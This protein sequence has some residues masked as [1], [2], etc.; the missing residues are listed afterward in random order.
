MT[1]IQSCPVLLGRMLSTVKLLALCAAMMFMGGEALAEM[2]AGESL[3]GNPLSFS[4]LYTNEDGKKDDN[5]DNYGGYSFFEKAAGGT[6]HVDRPDGFKKNVALQT[7]CKDGYFTER[8]VYCIRSIIDKAIVKFLDSF[9]VALNA[10]TLSLVVL[11][12]TLFGA[13][14]LVGSVEKPGV[15]AFT[16]LLKIGAV[17]L[18]TN[19]FGG[20]VPHIFDS[21]ESLAGYAMSYI[22]DSA[23]SP[24]LASCSEAG[25]FYDVSIWRRIDCIIQRLFT[26][27]D[28]ASGAGYQAGVLWV[29]AVAI[30]WTTFLGFF[31]FGV[32]VSTFVMI[33]LLVVRCVYVFLSAYAMLSLLIIISP[34]IIPLVL[35]KSTAEHFTK[36]LKQ[37]M[38]MILLPMLLFAYMAFVFA[39]IDAMFFK[40][41]PY[42]LARILGVNWE[43]PVVKHGMDPDAVDKA[44]EEYA[45]KYN[46]EEDD[47]QYVG[48]RLH[49]EQKQQYMAVGNVL[50]T[51]E[52][53]VSI[54]I[55][56]AKDAATGI[57]QS[58]PVVGRV[59]SEGVEVV[60]D[61]IDWALEELSNTL[62]P[63]KVPRIKPEG[64]TRWSFM[65]DMLQFFLVVV[66]LLP[67][68]KK[69][70]EDIPR[71]LQMLT[72][73]K[74]IPGIVMPI[75]EQVIGSIG[76]AKGAVVEGVKGAV[77]GF[78]TGGKK[79]AIVGAAQGVVRGGV[80]GYKKATDDAKGISN[81]KDD[82]D[83]ENKHNVHMSKGANVDRKVLHG[84]SGKSDKK[85]S[86]ATDLAIA[87]ATRGKGGG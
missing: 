1:F 44:M 26:G 39:I 78:V 10:Y 72:N 84:E 15:D 82:D 30:F 24:F 13:Q 27:N 25:G 65:M 43:T 60:A 59:I 81:A 6:F 70:T 23:Q 58:V 57:T 73:A 28:D 75:E 69:Y 5:P 67:L 64:R 16:L 20:F 12:V 76:A 49:L 79:G 11:A 29:L 68:L 21:M 87:L 40:D 34:L 7:L 50:I 22:G 46:F 35:F 62:I 17:L 71:L 8:I 61:A 80:R 54:N 32:M 41:E 9:E 86:I 53:L 56:L 77:V 51:D 47:E 3:N 63:F 36:W 18:F 2:E 42:S 4:G 31:V 55:N 14:I 66:T 52:Q 48:Y 45:E 37:V 19:N 38:S 83:N 85:G 33:F 74:R